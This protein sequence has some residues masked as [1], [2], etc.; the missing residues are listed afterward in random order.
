ML[1]KRFRK[2][3]SFREAKRMQSEIWSLEF[4][5]KTQIC[6]VQVCRFKVYR[7]RFKYGWI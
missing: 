4:W 7:L 3:S 5:G 6:R 1:L 2:N